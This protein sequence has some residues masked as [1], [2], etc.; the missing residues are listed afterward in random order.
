M[1]I[2]QTGLVKAA[3]DYELDRVDY[4][5]YRITF[6]DPLVADQEYRV[7][8]S[9][10]A[11]D[12]HGVNLSSP[13]DFSF[14]TGSDVDDTPPT[15]TYMTP[16]NGSTVNND[17]GTIDLFFSEAID[18]ESLDPTELAA[19]FMIYM[20]AEP[21]WNAPDQLTLY[22]RT[23]LPAGVNFK[24]V[25]GIGSFMDLVG[26]ENT[27]A[28]TAEFTVAGTPDYFPVNPA[29]KYYYWKEGEGFDLQNNP[30]SY[31][32][33]ERLKVLFDNIDGE[34]CERFEYTEVEMGWNLDDHWLLRKTSSGI[35]FRGFEEDEGFV[36]FSPEINYLPAPIPGTWSGITEMSMGEQTL[37]LTFSG[38]IIETGVDLEGLSED[39]PR[40]MYFDCIVADL[41]H[42]MTVPDVGDTV[43]HGVERMTLCPGIGIVRSISEE[44][45]YQEGPDSWQ[46][47]EMV[48]QYIDWVN[49]P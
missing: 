48:L 41:T 2:T 46:A 29:F 13:V 17:Q 5:V 33:E 42:T 37:D 10:D 7:Q 39:G 14:T 32:Y 23:P 11:V 9:T 34:L 25:F 30:S 3:E 35:A 16:A 45:E 19:Q 1:S 24:A 15:L 40:I 22:L 43:M 47:S 27:A 18:Q 26:N 38:E 36:M 4:G 8:V 28:Y 21:V 6:F 20:A 49:V 31:T 44:T 12:Q